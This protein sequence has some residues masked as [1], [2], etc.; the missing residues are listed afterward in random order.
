[1]TDETP[2]LR[3]DDEDRNRITTALG[4][5]LS[6]GQLSYAEFDERTGQAW[7]ATHRAELLALLADLL[8]DPAR[9]LDD[10]SPAPPAGP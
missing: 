4:E 1:M 5:A 6:R 10:R 2:P 9:L 3:A 7:A 8:P